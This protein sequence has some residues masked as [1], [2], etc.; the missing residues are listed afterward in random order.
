MLTSE[1]A[2]M[3][4]AALASPERETR[5]ML[6]EKAVRVMATLMPA[7]MQR[8]ATTG[9]SD[10]NRNVTALPKA[11]PAQKNGNMY[12]PRKPPQTV[13]EIATSLVK[14]AIKHAAPLSS[15]KWVRPVVGQICAS[16][17]LP[18]VAML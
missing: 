7:A 16:G 3:G 13:N 4:A 15:W 17:V 2:M 1:A 14:P 18:R 11:A 5:M 9:E 6:L 10:G 8:H 12:P